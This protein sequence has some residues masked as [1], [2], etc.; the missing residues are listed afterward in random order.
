MTKFTSF[1]YNE[2]V[3]ISEERLGV[4]RARSSSVRE[5]R[6]TLKII[7]TKRD[8]VNAQRV[9]TGLEG[10]VCQAGFTTQPAG[11]NEV[12]VGLRIGSTTSA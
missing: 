5:R 11:M 6:G 2:T 4:I 10:R 3:T 1:L 8:D 7:Q 12:D 9:A